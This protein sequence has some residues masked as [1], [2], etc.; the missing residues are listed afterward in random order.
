VCIA[1]KCVLTII[2]CGVHY[3]LLA[4]RLASL[5]DL[6]ALKLVQ[7]TPIIRMTVAAA[8]DQQPK[9]QKQSKQTSTSVTQCDSTTETTST[10]ESTDKDMSLLQ[11]FKRIIDE[12]RENYEQERRKKAQ[13]G[14]AEVS[15]SMA[16]I[17]IGLLAPSNP[18]TTTADMPVTTTTTAASS[19]SKTSAIL[20]DDTSETPTAT[21]AED[22]RRR[23]TSTDDTNSASRRSK[24]AELKHVTR[25]DSQENITSLKSTAK[26][27]P[28]QLSTTD[29]RTFSFLKIICKYLASFSKLLLL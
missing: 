18:A 12:K 13:Q 25:E 9:Q 16:E 27:K 2:S 5:R 23:T 3:S 1:S 6:L 11:R 15:A 22:L 17:I 24:P 26:S 29:T 4:S 10:S 21:S 19:R 20:E 8:S 28:K 14:S 7:R